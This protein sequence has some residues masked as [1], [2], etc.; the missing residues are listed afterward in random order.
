[1]L[2]HAEISTSHWWFLVSHSFMSANQEL[3]LNYQRACSIFV[4]ILSNGDRYILYI[5][6]MINFYSGRNRKRKLHWTPKKLKNTN[7]KP[8]FYMLHSW[9]ANSL[10]EFS[11]RKGKFWRLEQ[12]NRARKCARPN[13]PRNCTCKL[14]RR[15]RGI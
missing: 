10:G 12:T 15:L 7:Y 8:K 1:M 6:K 11:P 13:F 4:S 5:Y 14:V 2:S 9:K 3:M